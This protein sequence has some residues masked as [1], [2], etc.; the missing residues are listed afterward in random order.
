LNCGGWTVREPHYKK[1]TLLIY[2]AAKQ[3]GTGFQLFISAD[4]ASGL[5]SDETRDMI[6]S[7]RSHPNQFR[8]QGR[9]VLSTFAGGREQ[10]DF[11]AHEFTGD[12][13]ICYVPFFYPT[14]TREM[15]LQPQVDQVFNDYGNTLDGFFH[16]GA[17][18]TPEQITESNRLLA[19]KWLGAGKIFMA[20]V[21]PYYRGMGGNYRAYETRGFEGM[22]QEWEG[23]IRDQATWVEIV[24]WND[25]GEASYIVPFGPAEQTTFW[26]GHWGPM[27]SHTAFLDAS[28]Y[29]I[30]WYKTGTPP[31]I[32]EDAIYYF[33]RTSPKT[34]PGIVKPGDKDSRI[35]LPRRADLLQ[36][37]VFATA[38]L[39]APARLVIRSGN[40]E[41]AFDLAA[42]VNHVSMPF[43]PGKPRFTLTRNGETIF[44][45]TG[46]QAISADEAWGD[47]N[48][49]SGAAKKEAVTK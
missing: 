12:R 15:P 34:V 25:W 38:F 7:F 1:R 40:T 26:K 14:P 29:Y 17:A 10:A 44:D 41:K 13:A 30:A 19:Q 3:L 36:D 21:T 46:E 22:A 5:T 33:Y 23:A 6:E 47:F 37:N 11:V 48:V 9:P 45:K 31:A 28:R 8:H 16:F 42:G 24:T 27:L 39:T 2:E 35:A 49:F 18:G 43:A 32:T 20:S 4:Y